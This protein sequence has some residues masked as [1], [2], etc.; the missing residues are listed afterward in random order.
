MSDAPGRAAAGTLVLAEYDPAWPAAF[1]AEA[2]R[3]RAAV[4]AHVIAIEHVGSTSVPGLLAKPVID[5]AVAVASE[6][7]AD[8]CVAPMRAMGYEYRGPHG[9][10]PARRYYALDR[11]GRRAVQVHL[12]I[13]PAEGWARH[14]RFRDLLRGSPALA[15]AY[16]REKRRVAEAVGWDKRAYA[17][18]K[19]PFIQA[20]L[21]GSEPPR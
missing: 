18:A 5:V 1:E 6:R 16:A 14:L 3:L 4:G 19:G 10:D 2:A 11:D 12:W 20:L 7:A 13:V 9:D 8:A 15:A 21:R 17:E